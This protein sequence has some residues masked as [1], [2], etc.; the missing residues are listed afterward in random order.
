M[1]AAV[2]GEHVV[3]GS[4]RRARSDSNGL[5]A[6][7][8]VRGALNQAG[9]ER[10]V[11]GLLGAAD[12]QHLLVQLEQA[13]PVDHG[14]HAL[15]PPGW[16]TVAWPRPAPAGGSGGSSPRPAAVLRFDW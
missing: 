7:R 6:G 8:E 16:L 14:R 13:R 4:Q 1:V 5:V 2:G 10:V 11:R 15:S 9:E 12:D 3:V